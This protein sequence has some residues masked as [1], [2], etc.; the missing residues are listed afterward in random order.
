MTICAQ[1]HSAKCGRWQ[2]LETRNDS[3]RYSQT[4]SPK[5][6][7]HTLPAIRL[8]TVLS[9]CIEALGSASGGA[10]DAGPAYAALSY[11]WGNDQQVKLRKGNASSLSQPGS[12]GRKPPS[13]SV[14]D[15]IEI[16]SRLDVGI[17]YRWVD[18]LCIVQDSD[19]DKALQISRMGRT[20]TAAEFTVVVATGEDADAGLPGLREGTRNVTQSVVA[21][22][23]LG[24]HRY[25]DKGLKYHQHGLAI[26]DT[27]SPLWN[28]DHDFWTTETTPPE[29]GLCKKGFYLDAS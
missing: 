13:Q 20:Y 5:T 24:T 19:E 23:P 9:K 29:D 2:A 3:E 21:V 26:T 25:S 11:I 1:G 16:V 8:I 28:E 7:L 10:T 4:L 17:Q 27:L 14:V 15:A 12:I 22:V 18:A 6:D